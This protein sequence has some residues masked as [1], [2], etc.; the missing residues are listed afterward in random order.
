MVILR[1][2]RFLQLKIESRFVIWN[3]NGLAPDNFTKVSLLRALSVTHDYDIICLLE[4]F[5]GS[6]ISNEDEIIN[7]KGYNLLL[8]DHR[9]NKMRTGVCMYY[10]E[11][12]PIIK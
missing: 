10:K 8:A 3:L 9:S 12:I 7:I 11:H 1:L 5:L 2:I 6:S 4:T